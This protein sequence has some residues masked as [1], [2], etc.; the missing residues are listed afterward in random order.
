M[1]RGG[2]AKTTRVSEEGLRDLGHSEAGVALVIALLTSVV[3]LLVG[4]GLL[5][6]TMTEVF[7]AQVA[8]D[9]AKAL[10]VAE[11]GLAHAV[12]VLRN[13]DN[14]SDQVGADRQSCEKPGGWFGLWDGGGCM[15]DRPYPGQGGVSVSPVPP[16]ADEAKCGIPGVSVD[17][18]GGGGAPIGSKIGDYTVLFHSGSERTRNTLRVRVIG[19]VG[20]AERGIEVVLE[21]VGP[22]DFVAYSASTV[23]STVRS[24]SGTFTVHG[25]VYI[26]GDWAFKGNSAQFNDRPTTTRDGAEPPYENQT[27]VCGDLAMQGSAQIGKPD[28]R[29]KA[30]H[31]A[32]DRRATGNAQIYANRVDKAVPDI[33]LGDVSQFVSDIASLEKYTNHVVSGEMTVLTWNSAEGNWRQDNWR[34]LNINRSTPTFLLPKKG[35]VEGCSNAAGE[36]LNGDGSV[37]DR[38]SRRRV[39][40]QCAAYYDGSARRWYAAGRQVIY[41]PGRIVL[42]E[43]NRDLQITYVVDGDPDEEQQPQEERDTA[44][45]VVGCEG[46]RQEEALVVNRGAQILARNRG[47]QNLHYARRDLL[48]FVVNG[49]VR[50]EGKGNASR[51]CSDPSEQEQNAVFVTGAEMFTKFRLQLIGVIIAGRIVMQDDGPGQGQAYNVRWCQVPDLKELVADTLLGQ[52]LND[53]RSS[54]IVV[55]RWQEIGLGNR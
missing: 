16:G 49:D 23:D 28:Q 48:A 22:L 12:Q 3:L 38:G 27:F 36:N 30:V 24:G 50:L 10:N 47:S 4:A 19:K 52:F 2:A 29:M 21:R 44:M 34:D 18:G 20:R 26:R 11:A 32:G 33:K 45:I 43:A 55:R 40:M 9:S 53:P 13:D 31:V 54:S 5:T 25:S 41:V 46:C 37:K 1:G 42:G 14:W 17:N 7:T 8:E 35:T 6:A 39:L 15:E 51:D